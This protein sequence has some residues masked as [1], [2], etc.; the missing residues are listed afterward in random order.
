MALVPPK[1]NMC[2][3]I[4]DYSWPANLAPNSTGQS[5]W[6][7]DVNRQIQDLILNL[8]SLFLMKAPSYLIWSK[9][10]TI[11]ILQPELWWR[12]LL[13]LWRRNGR[14][15]L[16]CTSIHESKVCQNCILH[17]SCFT[18]Y[19][20]IEVLYNLLGRK[21]VMW[22]KTLNL[23]SITVSRSLTLQMNIVWGCEN[24]FASTFWQL[25]PVDKIFG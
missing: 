6:L 7:V 20:L 17:F 14:F 3:T 15:C 12:E 1:I 8:D 5:M 21:R 13:A 25:P 24:S 23:T 9:S 18:I 16:N 11:G 10:L 4:A 22:L 2:S 19:W